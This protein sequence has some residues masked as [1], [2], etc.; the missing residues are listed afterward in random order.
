MFRQFMN[1]PQ[2]ETTADVAKL[3]SQLEQSLR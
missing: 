3:L 2:G 1:R